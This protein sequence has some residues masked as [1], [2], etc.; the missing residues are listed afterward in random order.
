MNNLKDIV[1]ENFSWCSHGGWC[2]LFDI[3]VI[4]GITLLLSAGLYVSY[5]QL[6]PK[7]TKTHHIWDDTLLKALYPTLQVIL[8]ILGIATAVDLLTLLF[9][10]NPV[11][12]SIIHI[13]RNLI[14]I[15]AFLW[16][17]L[18]YT[19]YIENRLLQTSAQRKNFDR[20]TIYATGKLAR[21]LILILIALVIIQ[22]FGIPISG[23]TTFLGAAVV[24]MGFGAKDVLS[25]IF[26]GFMLYT[27]RPFK[28]GD[29]IHSSDKVIEGKVEY[30]GWRSTRV[31][32]AD[33]QPLY[34]PNSTFL[35]ITVENSTRMLRRHLKFNV[36]LRY[37]D[38][39]L[40]PAI[41]QEIEIMLRAHTEIATEELVLAQLAELSTSTLN[42]L[43]RCYTKTTDY[44]LFQH[45]QQDILLK[46]IDIIHQHGAD[47][48]FPTTTL[49]LPHA[50][51]YRTSP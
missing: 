37:Q 4:L 39:K 33:F 50:I 18:K 44:V 13:I 2:W 36:G 23:V 38:A 29:W 21:I 26:G 30:I 31:L 19:S 41:T 8:W 16:F 51:N 45:I 49:D 47:F 5:R 9:D 3:A 20:T 32:T 17:L 28:V 6:H 25:N 34:V 14:I 11:F 24:G 43:V 27:D 35:G 40:I 22:L 42:I 46:V 10:D 48:A 12:F 15:I 7:L 1:L